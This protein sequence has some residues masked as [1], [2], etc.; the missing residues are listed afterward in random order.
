MD[1]HTPIIYE[2]GAVT[3]AMGCF[4]DKPYR[5]APCNITVSAFAGLSMTPIFDANLSFMQVVNTHF[6]RR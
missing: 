6:P 5:A 3:D 4:L 2:R 1:K